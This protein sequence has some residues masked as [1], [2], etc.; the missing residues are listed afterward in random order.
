VT[1]IDPRGRQAARTVADADGA[2]W[3]DEPASGP[4]TLLVSDASR[5]P[6]AS[7]VFVR[8]P[9]AGNETVVNVRLAETDSLSGQDGHQG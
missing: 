1:L 2:F 8:E 4:Y 7:T 9:A 3:L 6:A 5:A